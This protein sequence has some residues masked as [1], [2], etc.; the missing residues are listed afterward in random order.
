MTRLHII[1]IILGAIWLL[2]MGLSIVV[3]NTLIALRHTSTE[4]YKKFENS[5]IHNIAVPSEDFGAYF[6]GLVISCGLGVIIDW[7][8]SLKSTTLLIIGGS[9]AAFVLVIYLIFEAIPNIL[10]KKFTPSKAKL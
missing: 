6:P 9:I 4:A 3:D 7:I 10:V 5:W 2:H 8:L 1:W